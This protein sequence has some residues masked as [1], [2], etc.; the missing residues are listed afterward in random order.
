M[1][2]LHLQFTSEKKKVLQTND[3]YIGPPIFFFFKQDQHLSV[4]KI[5]LRY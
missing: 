5:Q 2:Y 1:S 4:N 3:M